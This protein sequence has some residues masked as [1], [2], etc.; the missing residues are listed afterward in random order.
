MKTSNI[1]LASV[2]LAKGG[3][4]EKIEVVDNIVGQKRVLFRFLPLKDED[5]ILVEFANRTLEVNTFDFVS[6]SRI[7]RKK[8][9]DE[10]EPFNNQQ[11]SVGN[12]A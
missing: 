8:I 2:F 1:D 7:I 11:I 3:E 12:D 9:K 4:L 10:I 6:A 5:K